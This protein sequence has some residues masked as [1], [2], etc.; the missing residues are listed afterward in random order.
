MGTSVTHNIF[1]EV[2][3]YQDNSLFPRG[4][5]SSVLYFPGFIDGLCEGCIVNFE[6]LF[7]W[8]IWECFFNLEGI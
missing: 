1:G 4:S 2:E 7:I 3:G 6:N 5:F 8:K